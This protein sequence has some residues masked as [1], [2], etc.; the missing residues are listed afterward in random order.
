[1]TTDFNDF[2]SS[3]DNNVVSLVFNELEDENSRDGQRKCNLLT[4]AL[5]TTAIK[6]HQIILK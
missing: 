3:Q 5:P 6:T 2:V 4:A 1:M